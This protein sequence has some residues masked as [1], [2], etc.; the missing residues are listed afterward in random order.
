MRSVFHS[1]QKRQASHRW[2]MGLLVL[3]ICMGMLTGCA[4][5]KTT[6]GSNYQ[7]VNDVLCCYFSMSAMYAL[8]FMLVGLV[9]AWMFYK[10]EKKRYKGFWDMLE[11]MLPGLFVVVWTFGFCVYATG[12]FILN[13][14][15]SAWSFNAFMH[16]LGVA[17]MAVIHAF[18]MFLLESD[19]SAIHEEWH[20]NVAFMTAF[21]LA[22]FL[23]AFVSL[24]FLVKHFGYNAIAALRLRMATWGRRSRKKL[25]VFWGMN[26]PSYLLAKDINNRNIEDA[27]VIF[28]M[29]ADDDKQTSERNGLERLFDLL[30][31]NNHELEKYR[32]LRCYTTSANSR[33]SKITIVDDA[34]RLT[35]VPILR[36]TLKLRGL[37]KLIKSTTEE[38]HIFMLGSDEESNIKATANICHDTDICDMLVRKAIDPTLLDT[39]RKKFKQLK[40][41]SNARA[42]SIKKVV[43]DAG[44][45]Y[46]N[47]EVRVLDASHMAVELLKGSNEAL[48][49][50]VHFVD[51]NPDAT[52]SSPFRAMVVG[53]G[54]TGR[55]AVRFLYEHAAF[56]ASSL[57]A[58]GHVTR[59]PFEC[60][61]FDAQMDSLGNTFRTSSSAASISPVLHEIPTIDSNL[62][63]LYHADAESQLFSD[64]VEQN[65]A[66]MNYVVIALQDD[67]DGISLAV[68]LLKHAIR[69]GN[70]LKRLR[71]FVRSYSHEVLP[72]ITEVARFYNAQI[73]ESLKLQHIN[74][75]PICLFGKLKDLY[76]YANV[77]DDA[78]RKESYHYYNSYEGITETDEEI[79]AAWQQ[80][81]ENEMKG[82]N[83]LYW[84]L[85]SVRR[86]EAQDTANALHRNAKIELIR[87]ALGTEA[88]LQT[89][90]HLIASKTL[91]R[92]GSNRYEG[93]QQNQALLDTLAQTEHLRWNASHEMMGYVKGDA[94]DESRFTHNCL[95][96]WD[97]LDSD[98]TRG[99]DYD[100]VETSLFMYH[101][102]QKEPTT[103]QY[104][105]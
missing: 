103:T 47:L 41:Y 59:S 44:Y 69:K 30:T 50:P 5:D 29:T 60:H 32:A 28:V 80:R 27:D 16:M 87:K 86:K 58:D 42:D 14:G 73:A 77:V 6:S 39:G 102:E 45:G 52:V 21:S 68:R 26:E 97:L 34:E 78:L 67:E 83:G 91:K 17:P 62:V 56:V 10:M 96:T 99:Y 63:R 82:G 7:E 61:V 31:M 46:A 66:S 54:P 85:N 104:K 35:T 92:D 64:F 15:G 89:L 3:F 43:E 57:D 37:V 48:T 4:Y 24:I 72:H 55:D 71:I 79:G 81:R 84:N 98:E 9:A 18:G 100:V 33:L 13:G 8:G 40:I 49:H 70:D 2:L 75:T 76:T 25:F 53:M 19:I 105:N 101:K 38:V 93:G 94:K 74:P 12:M 23:A 90:A 1:I 51:A 36:E 65:I 20:G 95:T 88:K 11:G 22:H